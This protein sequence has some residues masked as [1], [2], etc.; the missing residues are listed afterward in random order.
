MSSQTKQIM[1]EILSNTEVLTSELKEVSVT[2]GSNIMDIAIEGEEEDEGN[3]CFDEC[4]DDEVLNLR[5]KRKQEVSLEQTKKKIYGGTSSW[6]NKCFTLLL[7][8][9]SNDLLSDDNELVTNEC[10]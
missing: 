2:N 4:F 10:I 7:S 5:R 8:V 1:E 6:K 3:E 9:T